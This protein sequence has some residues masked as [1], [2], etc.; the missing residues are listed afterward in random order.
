MAFVLIFNQCIALEVVGS[1][2]IFPRI[3][4]ESWKMRNLAR[5]TFRP[6]ISDMTTYGT[7][8]QTYLVKLMQEL[9]EDIVFYPMD[10]LLSQ[11]ERW[12]AQ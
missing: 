4:R 12:Y 3:V 8:V 2:A 1:L 9:I 10:Y 7:L 5:P 6:G 11:K